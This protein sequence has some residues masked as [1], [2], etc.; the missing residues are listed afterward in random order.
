MFSGRIE[1]LRIARSLGRYDG[2]IPRDWD[3]KAA[4]LR[5]KPGPTKKR[6][7]PPQEEG[8]MPVLHCY[9]EVPCNPCISVC[10]KGA[11]STERDE[12]TGVPRFDATKGCIGCL[13]CVGICP[14]LAITVVDYRKNPDNPTVTLPYEIWREKVEV[15]S[16]VPVLDEEGRTLGRFTVDRVV[17]Y[18]KYP[19]TL[20]VQ[21]RLPKEIAKEAAGVWAQEADIEPS[22]IYEKEQLPDEAVICRCERVTAGEIRKA[23]RGGVRD[24]NHLKAI[25]R[26]GMG[27]CGSKTCRSMILRIFREEGVDLS[28]VTDRT[29]RPL[30]VEVP[31]GLFAGVDGGEDNG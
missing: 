11:L 20:M 9:Q 22:D 10:P 5:S 2:E 18:P 8:V 7:H 28:E 25:T 13:N 14:G 21:L 3:E 6:D 19:G 30:F 4:I 26:A 15:G 1:G 29:D 23:I 24:M 17:Q 12:I 31:L 27:A 16:Q